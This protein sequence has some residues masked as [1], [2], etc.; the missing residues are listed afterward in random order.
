MKNK[1]RILASLFFDERDCQTAFLRVGANVLLIVMILLSTCSIFYKTVIAFPTFFASTIAAVMGALTTYRL[2]RDHFDVNLMISHKI[3]LY[4]KESCP[5]EMKGFFA[6]SYLFFE[7]GYAL[8][9]WEKINSF[10]I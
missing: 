1:L 10:I 4:Q 5:K 9:H 7:F 6:L 8:F 2:Y 3:Y